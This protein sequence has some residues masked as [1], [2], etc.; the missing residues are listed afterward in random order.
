MY[1]H[2]PPARHVKGKEGSEVNRYEGLHSKLRVRLN[3]LIRQTHGYSK[4][5]YMLVGSLAMAWLRDGLHQRQ[6]V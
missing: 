3:R 5:L 2:L 1:S 4:R 6:P